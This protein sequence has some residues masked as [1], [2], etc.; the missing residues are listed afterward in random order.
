MK[1]NLY[2]A[3]VLASSAM[4][5]SCTTRTIDPSRETKQ[6]ASSPNAIN[7]NTASAEELEKLH[8]GPSSRRSHQFR[9][10]MVG[11]ASRNIDADPRVQ[12]PRYRE[13]KTS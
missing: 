4:L 9:S 13:I 5:V 8:I 6:A 3:F 12:R 11:F 1:R 7:I 2:L 10:G